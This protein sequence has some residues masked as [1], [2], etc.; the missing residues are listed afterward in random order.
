MGNKSLTKKYNL[1]LPIGCGLK[2]AE[3]GEQKLNQN[4]LLLPI[5]SALWAL[6]NGEQKLNQKSDTYY[7][8]Y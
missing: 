7:I 2:P 3:Y 4:N 5:C 8:I 6:H 1:L